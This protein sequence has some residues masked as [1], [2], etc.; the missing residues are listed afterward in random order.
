MNTRLYQTT[1]WLNS[2]SLANKTESDF[3]AIYNIE[4]SPVDNLALTVCSNRAI[5]CY[6]SRLSSSKPI[7][8]L[9]NAHDDA[10]NCLTF[11]DPLTFAT[12][13]DDKTIRIWDLRQL[14]YSIAV[15]QGHKNWVKNIEYDKNSGRLFSVGLYDGV[16]E[17]KMDK[18][19]DYTS[20]QY[21]NLVFEMNLPVQMRLSPNSNK[22]FIGE[23]DNTCTV[24]D[25]FNG[26]Y[27]NDIAPVI[28]D[29]RDNFFYTNIDRRYNRPSIYTMSEQRG[30]ASDTN[31]SIKSPFFFHCGEFIGLRHTD[32]DFRDDIMRE[33]LSLLDLRQDVY[34]PKYSSKDCQKKYLKYTKEK[35]R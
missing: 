18:M 9:Q 2:E 13:S 1:N 20:E 4:F 34:K 30:T 6:D 25:H 24:I 28:K 22:M 33:N 31:R 12:C 16:R 8:A 27:L 17:W 7:H 15:L 32:N 29:L 23:H 5:L 11:I 10:V 19:C 35:G 21:D 26:N 14:K 3:G